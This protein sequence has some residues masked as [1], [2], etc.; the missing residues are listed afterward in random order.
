MKN[1]SMIALALCGLFVLNFATMSGTDGTS[2]T[3]AVDMAEDRIYEMRIYTTHPGKLDDLH[4]RFEDH[5]LQLFAKHGMV[6]VGYWVPEDPE[7]RDNTLIYILSHNSQEA[8]QAS[9]EGFRND[10]DWQ[11]AYAA[12]REDGPIVSNVESIFMKATSYSQI[13]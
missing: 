7:R 1:L 4:T 12:S 3:E 13:R 2:T 11:A 6:N 10:P 9:W 8:A 5:T